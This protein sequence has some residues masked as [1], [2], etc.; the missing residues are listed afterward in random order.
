MERLSLD[1]CIKLAASYFGCDRDKVQAEYVMYN[2]QCEFKGGDGNHVFDPAEL[3]EPGKE[4]F[5]VL[6]H[7]DSAELSGRLNLLEKRDGV[8]YY[9]L[10]YVLNFSGSG[11]VGTRIFL[12]GG[13]LGRLGER[14]RSKNEGKTFVHSNVDMAFFDSLEILEKVNGVGVAIDPAEKFIC[15]T[16][17]NFRGLSKVLVELFFDYTPSGAFNVGSNYDLRYLQAL[18]FAISNNQYVRPASSAV[19]E[20]ITFVDNGDGTGKLT[21]VA[22]VGGGSDTSLNISSM[23]TSLTA[24]SKGTAYSYSLIQSEF[25]SLF[26]DKARQVM[27]KYF[28]ITDTPMFVKT[29]TKWSI[30]LA[31]LRL[32]RTL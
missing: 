16:T 23:D 25:T 19:Y 11:T 6:S 14:E 12:D 1:E 9:P 13:I 26:G 30:Q 20:S 7:A 2:R 17:V 4:H 5:V 29:D 3:L 15:N 24:Y 8:I 31:Y 32:M 10:T 22:Y 21:G 28:D 27:L 18:S